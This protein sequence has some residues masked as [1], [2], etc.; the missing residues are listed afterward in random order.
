MDLGTGLTSTSLL[1]CNGRVSHTLTLLPDGCVTI[2]FPDGRTAKVSP[3][4][5]VNHTPHISVTPSL[6]DAA[7]TLTPF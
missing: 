4:G 2:R 6:M 1:D 3:V 5:R 7:C